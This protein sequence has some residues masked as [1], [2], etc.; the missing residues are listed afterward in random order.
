MSQVDGRAAYGGTPER[1]FRRARD[2]GSEGA[3]AE[4][5]ARAVRHDG[6][7][8]GESLPNPETGGTGQPAYPWRGRITCDAGAGAAG[9]AGQDG[10]GGG[11]GRGVPRRGG[12]GR[13]FTPGAQTVAYSGP[14]EWSYRRMVLHYAHLADMAGG[15]D[16]L[17]HRLGAGRAHDA[18]LG[19]ERLSLRGGAAGARG[20][21]AL[22]GRRGRRRFPMRPTGASIS[23]TSRRTASGDV[24]F[25]LDPL[26]ADDEDRF[27]RHRPLPPARPTGATSAGHADE[28]SGR[29]PYDLAYL[30]SNVRGG[31]GFDWYYASAEDRDGAGAHADHRRRAR[32]AVGVPL[33]GHRVLVGEPALRPAGRRGGGVADRLD[34]AGQADL[35]D[36]AR[37]PGGRQG[38]Q[39]AER[40]LRSEIGAVGAALFFERRARRSRSSAPMSTRI[41]ASSTSTIRSSTDRTRCRRSM[42]GG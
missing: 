38:R 20:R 25:H 31:E 37:L 28:T 19:D 40:V 23:G 14:A 26:W 9:L 1:P 4:G 12:A 34:A 11:R 27:R 29:S 30:R 10:G 36:R 42:A 16:A 18:P 32:Q 7:P 22:G 6:H 13:L 3:R 15:V 24:H 35:A 33:Q 21:R 41:S 39:P 17:P 2:R 8:G 5:A